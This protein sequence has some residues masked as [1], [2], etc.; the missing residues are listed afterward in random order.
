MPWNPKE[1][2]AKNKKLSPKEAAKA[3]EIANAVL[4]REDGQKESQESESARAGEAIRIANSVVKGGR[5]DGKTRPSM[6]EV[7]G[8][9]RMQKG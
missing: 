8:V 2:Q 6:R 4:E 7:E 5:K 1:M 9:R 3:A